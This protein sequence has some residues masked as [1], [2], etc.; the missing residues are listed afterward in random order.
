MHHLASIAK[1]YTCAIPSIF[2][3]LQLI[4]ATINLMLIMFDFLCVASH[5]QS[6]FCFKFTDM[7]INIKEI[8]NPKEDSIMNEELYQDLITV[9]ELCEA[10]TVGKNTAYRLLNNKEISAFRIGRMWKIPR[11]SVTA[12]IKKRCQ[13]N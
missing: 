8:C 11:Q 13:A 7:N 4:Q 9:E 12:F 6:L 3:R 5:L 10:L 1:V 2:H